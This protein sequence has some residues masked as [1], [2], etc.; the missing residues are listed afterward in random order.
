MATLQ[1]PDRQRGAPRVDLF[2]RQPPCNLEAERNTLGSILLR[3]ETCD[4]VVLVLRPEDFYD[5]AHRTMYRHVVE[6]HDGGARIDLTLLIERL[7]TAG[8]FEPIGG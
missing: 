3:P 6:M 1:G 7:K 8:D 2:D 4:D 5:D